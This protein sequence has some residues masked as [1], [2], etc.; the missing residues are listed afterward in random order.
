[1]PLM[2][3]CKNLRCV[4][5]MARGVSVPIISVLT[6]FPCCHA[7]RLQEMHRRSL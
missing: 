1:M 3:W 6:E 5:M 7:L 2:H 4:L